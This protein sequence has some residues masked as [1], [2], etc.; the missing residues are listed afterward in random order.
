MAISAPLI[1]NKK[2]KF[3]CFYN[4]LI[5]CLLLIISWMPVSA[6]AETEAFGV[7]KLQ[8]QD[9]FF[10]AAPYA[11]VTP[12]PDRRISYRTLIDN[13]NA[14]RRGQRI[15][16]SVINL[17][18]SGVPHWIVI[19][20]NNESWTDNW[21]LSFGQHLGGRI[22]TLKDISVY[23]NVTNTR[24][25]DTVSAA[26]N[27]YIGGG[28][29][30]GTSVKV[31]LP[32]GK[33]SI[34]VIYVVPNLGHTVTIAPQLIMENDYIISSN[35]PFRSDR[36]LS[37]FLMIVFGF[38]VGLAVF[39]K[40]RDGLLLVAYFIFQY[41][42]F[43]YHNNTL[44]SA[45]GMENQ[46]PEMLL[47]AIIIASILSSKVFLNIRVTEPL[48]DK[49]LLGFMIGSILAVIVSIFILPASMSLRSV[50]IILPIIGGTGFL[51]M[52]SF[53][54][55]YR[56]QYGARQFGFAWLVV[57]CGMVCTTLALTGM[58]PATPFIVAAY[59]Y[60][61][62]PQGILMVTAAI[63]K[64]YLTE[65]E[66]LRNLA[67]RDENS[68]SLA[69]LRQ[70]KETA[71]INRLKR[72]IEHEREVMN[73]LREREVQQN[74]EMR[75]SKDVA[76]EAN[77]AKSAFLAVISHEIRTPMSGIMGMIRLL[78]ESKLNKDQLDYAQ[79]IQDSG[80]AMLSLLN[81]ILDFEKI[82]SGKMELEHIDFDL[83]RVINS[84]ITLMSGHAASKGLTLKADLSANVPRYVIGD[85]VRLRQVL[86]NLT[87]NSIK[88]TQ[89]GSVTLRVKLDPTADNRSGSV[90]R[91]RFA[92]EDTGVGI[93][94]E[95]QKNLF[96]PFAQADS[97]TARKFGGTGLG[98]AISQRLIEAMGGKIHIDSTEGRGSI[99]FFT[100]IVENGSA[101]AVEN[102]AAKSEFAAKPEKSLRILAVEDNEINQKLLKEFVQRLG[103]QIT[104]CGSGEE[105]IE[106]ITNEIFDMILMDINLPGLSGMGTTKAIRAIK[107]T[108]KASIPIIALTGKS[109]DSEIRL[110]YTV[111]MNG[112][113][114]KPVDPKR[115]KL[116]IEKVIQN[117][118]DN[119]VELPEKEIF[120]IQNAQKPILATQQ[121]IFPEKK[122]ILPSA[123]K[124]N[125][126]KVQT[127]GSLALIL[128]DD[129]SSAQA[130]VQNQNG[131][132]KKAFD[133]AAL[134]GLKTA[135]GVDGLQELVDGLF[136]KIDEIVNALT[137][138]NAE[139]DIDNIVSQ[140]HDLKGMAGNFGLKEMSEAAMHIENS[141]SGNDMEDMKIWCARLPALTQRSREAIQSWLRE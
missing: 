104:L 8:D 20:L 98:L 6:S 133:E 86:L 12:D 118:L 139:Q 120:G 29:M 126:V 26:Q 97:S 91:I 15:N 87:G 53:A 107:D 130:E 38:F 135:M 37:R 81:D 24:Y 117:K 140:A 16:D 18:A 88:F 131:H 76:D 65:R 19:V 94:R 60:A 134:A 11:Y 115:L 64:F 50:G 119:P 95:A 27:P 62:L 78:L 49:L 89:Q 52:L 80:D 124:P 44:Y 57:F 48:Q 82:E 92:V 96:N 110:C 84:I 100:L 2:Q 28:T 34:F 66:T 132:A 69:R 7:L 35:D 138:S 14:G 125:L 42:L 56:G 75:K 128:E 103:H 83:H 13:F 111:N 101:D 74:E 106:I 1:Q 72:L 79:T 36:L 59:W 102:R 17:G 58:I 99:F 71:E 141:A 33:R 32:K 123:Q 55:A 105:A 113:L 5:F 68:E 4:G 70:S 45:G 54:Q 127:E 116:M 63:T 108:Q 109:Q 93:S 51:T 22:G 43:Q 10:N 30:P 136:F 39:G 31:D 47:C 137:R 46:I 112:H 61:L 21:I 40:M 67:T 121:Q 114:V 85:P 41:A 23:E 122:I 3:H 9:K 90:H 77:R 25:V 129:D 73:T